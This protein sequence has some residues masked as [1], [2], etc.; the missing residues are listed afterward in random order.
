M[1]LTAS[2]TTAST[3]L[4][5]SA[6][7]AEVISANVA[8]ALT[9]GYA[10]REVTVSSSGAEGAVQGVRV[11]GLRR[12]TDPALTADRRGA[13]SQAAATGRIA[14]YQ[15]AVET[16]IGSSG[17]ANGLTGRIAA[18]DAT[19]IEAASRPDSEAWLGRVL[20]AARGLADRIA[21]AATTVQDQRRAADAGIARSVAA[22]NEGLAGVAA[23]NERI[24]TLTTAGRD[25]S[26]LLDERQTLVDRLSEIVPLREVQRPDGQIALF[27]TGGA[28][29]LDGRPAKFGF[30]PTAI[31]DAEASIADGSLS[32]LT[33]NGHPIR[34]GG[35]AGLMAGGVLAADFDIRDRLAPEA[36]ARLDGLARDLLER[37]GAAGLDPTLAPGAPG[38]FTDAGQAFSATSATGLAQRIAMNAAVD[39]AEGGAL[40]RL[41]SG[42]GAAV[43]GPT[44]DAALLVAL[45][46]ALS[47]ARPTGS[48]AFS[49]QSRSL[50]GLAAEI[51]TET[52]TARLAAES[53]ESFA[54]ARSETLRNEELA[55]GVDTDREMQNLLSVERA[56]AANAK[57]IQTVDELIR[58][59]LGLGG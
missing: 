15:A 20:T 13:E 3:G 42:L 35:E 56:Y 16:A 33:L 57:V 48:P 31:I 41:R 27:S 25:V 43:Q 7:M 34:M 50:S 28:V 9:P 51:L 11:T 4:T 49:T 6:R 44:G 37:T 22:L 12:E 40:W 39:P 21:S 32:G 29:L 55:M 18:L 58:M 38:L 19:L 17:D 36:Q 46:G 53:E 2:L 24:R 8:N 30:Q 5:V 14:A 45:T 10:R 52:S 1:G 54:A 59:L 23:A 47:E 26:S